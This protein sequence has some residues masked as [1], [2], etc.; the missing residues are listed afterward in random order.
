MSISEAAGKKDDVRLFTQTTYTEW[1]AQKSHGCVCD[2][3]FTGYDCSLRTCVFGHDPLYLVGTT[4]YNE[5]QA[6]SCTGT[7]GE[8]A[9]RFR[10]HTTASISNSAI[11]TTSAES[12]S[13]TGTGV[14]E[15]LQ[16]KLEALPGID[17]V[18][19]SIDSNSA[20]PI[21]DSD[22]N[23]FKVTFTRQHGDLPTLEVVHLSASTVTPVH[24]SGASTTGTYTNFECN[25][26][27]TCDRSTGLCACFTGFSS[28]NGLANNVQGKTGDCGYT[29]GVS[30]CSGASSC[31][32][33]GTCSGSNDFRCTCF[34]GWTGGDCSLRTCPFDTAWW[35]EPSAADTAHA[36]AECSGRGTCDRSN[37]LC[38]CQDGFRGSACQRLNCPG[39]GN[40]NGFGSCLSLREAARKRVAPDGA[41]SATSFGDTASVK[42]TWTA[43]KIYGCVCDDSR[44]RNDVGSA[45]GF[46]GSDCSQRT[47]QRGDNFL[48]SDQ[49]DEVQVITC[50][51]DGGS[52]TLTFR[53]ETSDPIYHDADAVKNYV[54][55]ADGD[56]TFASSSITS[57]SDLTSILSSGDVVQIAG[58]GEVR[59]FTVSSVSSTTVVVNEKVGMTTTTGSAIEIRKIV[60]S[61]KNVLEGLQSI[62]T[63]SVS[64]T[65][66]D[67]T[68]PATTACSASSNNVRVTFLEE[69]GDLPEMTASGTALTLTSG[70]ASVSVA[71]NTTGTK[72]D[73]ECSNQGICDRA[74]GQCKC[75]PSQT[76]SDGRAGQGRRPD[77][78]YPNALAL[79]SD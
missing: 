65:A 72:E 58:N 35:D 37:G 20:T 46:T 64:I 70:S 56:V 61:V 75:F 5:V 18:T 22:G 79:G 17:A 10:G 40:C 4:K 51:A 3:G 73:A 55:I 59:N 19:V 32:G 12:G 2:V 29:T 48:T 44:F 42:A 47:C 53:D 16:S 27:G 52:F 41:A 43:D 50:T 7:T 60:A 39:N 33:H 71:T 68:T 76:A 11:A 62:R 78:G 26:R 31:S 6:F 30:A 69:F 34:E 57:A 21:C 49:V 25:N 36:P 9:F 67:G 24:Q 23:T 45:I 8:F 66:S 74:T 28:S 38:S 13:G 54:K 14:G 15:S 63:V 1:D 77:C